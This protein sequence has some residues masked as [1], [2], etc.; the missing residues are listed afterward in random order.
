[1][2][3]DTNNEAVSVMNDLI[4]TCRDGEKG[5]AAAAERADSA[6]LKQLFSTL[7]TQRKTFTHELEVE[8][9]RIGG[10][11]ADMGHAA[12]AAHRGWMAVKAAVSTDDDQSILDE[13]ERGEDYAKKAYADALGKTLPSDL[14]PLVMRQADDVRAAHDKVRDLRN[15]HRDTK[16]EDHDRPTA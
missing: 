3:S 1:M 9:E 16:H 13:C 8:V 15:Q 10:T 11:P 5:F 7:A 14:R 2:S 6:D 12:A 4:E